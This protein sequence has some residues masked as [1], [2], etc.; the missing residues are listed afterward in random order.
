[1]NRIENLLYIGVDNKFEE[2]CFYKRHGFGAVD[3]ILIWRRFHKKDCHHMRDDSP[4][5]SL[6]HNRSRVSHKLLP[7]TKS[8]IKSLF[9][10]F[11]KSIT[12]TNTYASVTNLV[13]I[14]RFCKGIFDSTI[15]Y[16]ICDCRTIIR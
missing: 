13:P 9:I 15:W 2:H 8:L 14:T 3:L 5:E 1:M 11:L 12:S 4:L 10:E 16:Q 6:H 7:K